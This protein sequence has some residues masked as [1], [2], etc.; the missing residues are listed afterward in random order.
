M[1]PLVLKFLLKAASL[2]LKESE[3][4]DEEKDWPEA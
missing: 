2:C 3:G 4:D 1:G